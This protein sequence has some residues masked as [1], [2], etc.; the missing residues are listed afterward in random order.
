[1]NVAVRLPNWLGDTVMAVPVLAAVRAAWPDARVLA[2]GPWAPLLAGQGLAEVLVDYPR[3]WSGRLRAADTVSRFGPDLA[4]VLPNSFESALAAWYWGARRRIGYAAGGRS[5]LLTDVVPLP[6]PRR[7]QIDEY[8]ALVERAGV[9]AVTREPRLAPPAVDA[10]ERAEV[11][12]L[13]DA[14]GVPARPAR[15]ATPILLGTPGEAPAAARVGAAV[16]VPSLVGRDRPA[17]LP[18]LLT[19][20][21]A[22]VSGDTGVGHLATALG[23]PSVTLFGPT[24]PARSAPRGRAAVVTHP[25]PCAPCFY[26]ACPIEHPCLRGVTPEEVHARAAALLEPVA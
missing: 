18:A 13:L 6:S 23:T 14:A 22:L 5:A 7:H 11:L 16:S 8:L 17:L 12:R 1:M 24:D 15:G 25:V 26:R 19:E 20:I 10:A 9:P 3:S 21:D 2:A 4:I